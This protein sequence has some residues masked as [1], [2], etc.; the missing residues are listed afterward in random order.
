MRPHPAR[1]HLAHAI[2]RSAAICASIVLVAR[3][4][5]AQATPPS[6]IQRAV[7]AIGGESA[8]RSLANTTVDFNS[9]AFGIGQEETPLSPARATLSFGRIVTDYRGTRRATTQELRAVTGAITR[10]RRIIAG[11]IGMTESNGVPAADAAPAVAAALGDIRLL[12]DRMLLAALDNPSALSALRPRP[13]RGELMDG[14]RY[15]NGPDTLSLWF[16]RLNGRLVL[17]ER[18]TD[19]GV[20]GDRRNTVMYTRWTDAGGVVLPREIDSEANGRLVAHTVIT[21]ASINATLADSMFAIPDSIVQRARRAASAPT[22]IVVTLV[23]VAPNVWRAEGQTHHS[24]VVKQGSGLLV[25]EMPQTSARSKAVLDTL[26]SR[27]P[28]VPIRTAVSTHHHWDHSGGVREYLA[29]GIPVVTHRRNVDFLRGITTARK[30]VAPDALSRGGR[31]GTV[32]AAT[33]AMSIGDGDA[34]VVLLELPNTHAE[35]MLAAYVPAIR[36]LFVADVIQPGPTMSP[37]GSR[38]VMAMVKASGITVDRV[39]GAHAGMVTWADVTA[40]AAR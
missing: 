27:F 31:A 23:E 14:V 24:L 20:L 19:D 1:S 16:D 17:A 36:A 6:L 11:G 10:Q 7:A 4:A 35:G 39:I 22:G 13:V 33:D 12:P 37:V 40:A 38:E 2:V 18:I 3:A 30:S 34:R 5:G 26:K 28:G 15:A 25:I 8:L 29:R 21:A 9:T 32:R